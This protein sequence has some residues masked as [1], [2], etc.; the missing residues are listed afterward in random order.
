MRQP[1]FRRGF[2]LI[3]LLVVIAIIAVLIGLLLPA[4]QKVREAASR[5]QCQNNLKQIALAAHQHHD[6]RRRLPPGVHD[7][8]GRYTT[9]FV[10]MLP[11]LEQRSLHQQWNFA[12]VVD[13]WRGGTDSR[14]ATV[15]PILVCP[16][17]PV[18]ANPLPFPESN[19]AAAITTYGGNGGTRMLP[20]E[21][22][23][24][25]GVF[26]INMR[27]KLLDIHDG[28][29][30]TVMFGE[31]IT[32]DGALDS[33]IYAPLEP[34]PDPPLQPM[35]IHAVWAPFGPWVA[36]SFLGATA[37]INYTHPVRYEPPPP[38]FPPM[39]PP[40][41]PW[42]NLEQ[43]WYDRLGAFGSNHPQG[44]NFALADGSVRFIEQTIPPSTLHAICTRAGKEV[45]PDF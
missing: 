2:T 36:G 19:Q 17:M 1:S 33:W 27:V 9:L 12:D 28:T 26:F 34:A 30:Q 24:R 7:V 3:E 8:A 40:P 6:A 45:V 16:S 4:I 25:D 20:V 11:Y 18:T 44:A 14:A 23:R 31:R 39:P 35:T 38:T 22:A 32:E 21:D 41:V 10:E 13:N 42:T 15:F 37:T 43:Q 29:S 5:L